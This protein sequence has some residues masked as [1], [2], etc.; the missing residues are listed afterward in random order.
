[1][2]PRVPTPTE[3][4]RA[5]RRVRSESDLPDDI[6]LTDIPRPSQH[7]QSMRAHRAHRSE[8]HAALR[9]GAEAGTSGAAQTQTPHD[10]VPRRPTPVRL[11]DDARAFDDREVLEVLQ[12]LENLPE[13]IQLEIQRAHGRQRERRVPPGWRGK[14]LLFLG[15]VGPDAEVRSK[16]VSFVWSLLFGL[17]Q[18]RMFVDL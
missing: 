12:G 2:D 4:E 6:S 14:I 5:L 17:V 16:L 11:H 10:R 7:R 3:L 13:D 9:L 15:Q 18:V 8:G 1:M